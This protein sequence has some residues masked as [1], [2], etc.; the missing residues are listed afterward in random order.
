[1]SSANIQFSK[2]T[3]T[4]RSPAELQDGVSSVVGGGSP[5][6]TVDNSSAAQLNLTDTEW[7]TAT[8]KPLVLTAASTNDVTLTAG[9]IT[10]A[11]APAAAALQSALDLKAVGD[12]A[13]V[14]IIKSNT[15]LYAINILG[16]SETEVF[17]ATGI[18][19]TVNVAVIATNV[20][21]SSE[22]VA[23]SVITA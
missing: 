15:A 20:T 13:F 2:I 17:A 5:A 19:S 16:D 10:S 18:R 11:G 9:E 3:D 7:K 1:M 12:S 6:V 23:L 8:F 14:K 21:A 4:G 22:A